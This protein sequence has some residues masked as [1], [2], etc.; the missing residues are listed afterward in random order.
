MD[1][2]MSL[3]D[4]INSIYYELFQLELYNKFGCEEYD[5]LSVFLMEKLDYEKELGSNLFMNDKELYY[6]IKDKRIYR[7]N[8]NE[9]RLSS[10]AHE[11]GLYDDDISN[12]QKAEQR[13]FAS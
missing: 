13:I 2:L 7:M 3:Y 1:E 4:M 11:C 9:I 5:S 8:G 6:K 10:F 12:N